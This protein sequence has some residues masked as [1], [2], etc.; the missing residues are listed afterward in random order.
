MFGKKGIF[1]QYSSVFL[2]LF[3]I[4]DLA[5]LILTGILTHY[6]VFQ[7]FPD[8]ALSKSLII[9]N[10]FFFLIAARYAGLYT[11]MRGKKSNTEFYPLSGIGLI[12]IG[13][14][15]VT[16]IFLGESNL[17]TTRQTVFWIMLWNILTVGIL[18][19]SRIT[20]RSG[21]KFSRAIGLN[22]RK[23]LL[24][25]ANANSLNVEEEIRLNPIHGLQIVGYLDDRDDNRDDTLMNSQYLGNTNQ[26]IDVVHEKDVDQIWITYPLKAEDRV[27]SLI[28][29]LRH[30]TTSI[31]YVIDTAVFKDNKKTITNFANIPL[32]DIDV[33]PMDGPISHNAKKVEDIV[34]SLVALLLLSPLFLI[35][36]IGI[37]LTS[38][39][40]VFYRQTRISWNNKPFD[41]LKFRSMPV[42]IED[43]TGPQWAAKGENRATKFGAFLRKTSLDELP[44]FINVLKG[45]MSIVGPRPERPELIKEFKQ[46]IP[47]YMKKHMVKAGITGW[48]Q[49]NGYRGD[50]DLQMRI[51]YDIEY[52]KNWSPLFDLQIAIMT[53][54]KGFMNKNAY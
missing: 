36:A 40:P 2:F 50:T 8:Q 43:K 13:S 33:S 47:D 52:I 34:G 14:L 19:F 25:G 7:H 24:I 21:L 28:A 35:I 20:I 41:I 27:K 4:I 32:L 9:L 18:V 16:A 37:K 6:L 3:R 53:I 39:G 5:V 26:I 42:D 10:C 49:V 45:D 23:I 44:Q 48:A 11:S 15:I 29:Q 31:R 1:R 38:P 51:K 54:F 30:E 12:L 17:G 22:Q 46:N